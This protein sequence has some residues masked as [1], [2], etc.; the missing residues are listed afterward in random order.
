MNA[1]IPQ[2]LDLEEPLVYG[3][4]P[5]RLCCLLAFWLPA[6]AAW[7]ADLPPVARAVAAIVLLAAG[8]AVAW[9]RW[10]SR[11]LD[12]WAVDA[13]LFVL[14]RMRGRGM[15]RACLS[16]DLDQINLL[17]LAEPPG[18]GWDEDDQEEE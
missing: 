12:R 11:P 17:A 14:R 4:T 15:D 8:A 2:D 6:L 1:R 16:V 3:L 18:P 10:R 9:G 13:G 7:R 5:T